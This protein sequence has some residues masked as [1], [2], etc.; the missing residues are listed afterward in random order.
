MIILD[1][2]IISELMKQ[3]PSVV[4]LRWAS[5]QAL[6][7]LYISTVTIA[8]ITY[9]IN[10]LPKGERQRFLDRSFNKIV[11]E[12]FRYKVFSFDESAAYF[13]GQIM[14]HRKKLGK[15][16]SVLD[17]QIAAIARA[18]EASVATRNIQDFEECG[19]ELI[20]PFEK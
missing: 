19:I 5:E 15:P 12:V 1:T 2:N 17:G 3:N 4:V 8:E 18:N 11:Q 14:G 6:G 9:G 10:V 13:Y 7:Q 20:N 16:M